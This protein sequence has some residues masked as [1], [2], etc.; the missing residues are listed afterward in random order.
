MTEKENIKNINSKIIIIFLST[1]FIA[2]IIFMG[3]SFYQ[4]NINKF[5]PVYREG[6][7]IIEKDKNIT[8]RYLT[9]YMKDFIINNTL[10]LFLKNLFFVTLTFICLCFSLVINRSDLITNDGKKIYFNQI[11]VQGLYILLFLTILYYFS[12]D[13]LIPR[14]ENK[15][16]S[17]RNLTL[18]SIILIDNGNKNYFKNKF[19][20]ALPYYE[21]YIKINEKDEKASEIIR[22]IKN[23]LNVQQFEEMK[24]E[25]KIDTSIPDT[26]TDYSTLADLSFE[27]KDYYTAWYY[28][29]QV[30]EADKT[31][32]IEA[33]KRIED[34]KKILKF[35]NSMKTEKDRFDIKELTKMMN[36]KEKEINHIYDLKKKAK[37][38]FDKGNY[39]EAYFIYEDILK[40]NPKLREVIKEKEKTLEFLDKISCEINELEHLKIYPGKNDFVFFIKYNTFIL[41]DYI[42]KYLDDYYIYNIKIIELDN[43]FNIKNITS[44]PYGKTVEN[45]YNDTE[46]SKKSKYYNFTLYSYSKYNR[47]EINFPVKTNFSSNNNE[48]IKDYIITLP[49]NIE[50]FYNFSYDYNK[51]FGFSFVKLFN[52]IKASKEEN[53]KLEISNNNVKIEENKTGKEF[54]FGLNINFIKAAIADKIS[55]IFLFF[56]ISLIFMSIAWRLKATY[57]IKMPFT[58]IIL[59]PAIPI[60]LYF[61]VNFLNM[62]VTSLYSLLTE[63][64]IFPLMLIIC[65]VINTVLLIFSIIYFASTQ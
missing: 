21:E 3:I 46:N 37:D 22:K 29:Q 23:T 8:N 20:Q 53:K 24:K 43:N 35:E 11:I 27:K 56:S 58:H 12:L 60:L 5:L 6:V 54:N 31:K 65:F 38:N 51:T 49:I 45:T 44:S 48:V 57:M 55:K 47:N 41:I 28:Y 17:M 34:I 59:L 14:F 40:I 15:L 62:I 25:L 63:I 33:K 19:S 36:E 13:F 61:F 9:I 42:I 7:S 4:Y 30:V 10:L 64:L 32:G 39:H 18:N 52:L 16:E 1:F 26:I 2:M 50:I